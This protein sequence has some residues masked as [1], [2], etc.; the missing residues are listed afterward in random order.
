MYVSTNLR[1]LA[2]SRLKGVFDVYQDILSSLLANLIKVSR[3]EEVCT[4]AEITKLPVGQLLDKLRSSPDTP[5]S[6]ITRL[7]E[8]IKTRRREV[9]RLRE[10]RNR[11]GRGQLPGS[12]GRD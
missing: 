9:Q 7:D 5:I 1:E 3:A 11:I 12:T 2:A 8:E 6:K 10:E 4:M